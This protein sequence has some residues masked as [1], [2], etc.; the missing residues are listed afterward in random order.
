MLTQTDTPYAANQAANGDRDGSIEMA[1]AADFLCQCVH[2]LQTWRVNGFGP[3][4]YKPG[5]SVRYRRRDLNEWAK[6]HLGEHTGFGGTSSVRGQAAPLELRRIPGFS[7]FF[8]VPAAPNR[9]HSERS[10]S[11]NMK[12][13]RDNCKSRFSDRTT[14]SRAN[15]AVTFKKWQEQ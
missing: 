4:I 7:A 13:Q 2:T 9:P 12:A 10:R 5:R 14:T 11:K 15:T 8:R 6:T 3:K 1:M